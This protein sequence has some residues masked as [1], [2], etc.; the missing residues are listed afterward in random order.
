MKTK[1]KEKYTLEPKF[2]VQK[3]TTLMMLEQLLEVQ[4]HGYHVRYQVMHNRSSLLIATSGL[5]GV[6]SGT[7]SGQI[8]KSF[9]FGILEIIALG[10]HRVK[11]ASWNSD[12]QA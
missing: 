3:E 1:K 2:A 12:N 7:D 10:G 8:G 6:I 9:E 5:I 11:R 4:V